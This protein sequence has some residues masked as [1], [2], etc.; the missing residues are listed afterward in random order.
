ML[1]NYANTKL[2][3]R[4]VRRGNGIILED[5]IDSKRIKIT[6]SKI[7]ESFSLFK[8]RGYR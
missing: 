1:E 5:L 6:N 2:T 4:K 8:F 3:A 7:H